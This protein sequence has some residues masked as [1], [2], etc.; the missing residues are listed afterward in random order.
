[1]WHSSSL[2]AD[3]AKATDA[4]HMWISYLMDHGG[5]G[6]GRN[7][8]NWLSGER[9]IPLDCRVHSFLQLFNRVTRLRM[10][11]FLFFF[12]ASTLFGVN[13]TR[14]RVCGS[15]KNTTL[16]SSIAIFVWKCNCKTMHRVYKLN[17]KSLLVFIVRIYSARSLFSIR[18][19]IVLLELIA[20]CDF[21]DG[22]QPIRKHNSIKS[23]ASIRRRLAVQSD[24]PPEEGI[25]LASLA[26]QHRKQIVK[27][28]INIILLFCGVVRFVRDVASP[29]S[30]PSSEKRKKS[31]LFF[32]ISFSP[33]I[34]FSQ[35]FLYRNNFG[36][37][38]AG[39]TL[40]LPS[41]LISASQSAVKIFNWVCLC[42][43]RNSKLSSARMKNKKNKT[44]HEHL[45]AR[46]AYRSRC[47]KMYN[48][49]ACTA[50]EPHPSK[51]HTVAGEYMSSRE[52]KGLT[53]LGVVK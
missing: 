9:F 20:F 19:R 1:M 46:L 24:R 5:E 14:L 37:E 30:T 28:A 11:G 41:Q 51:R 12:F 26:S 38:N 32:L 29:R 45:Y 8:L 47:H 4:M 7:Y 50:R 17:G 13:L 40:I 31:N 22:K 10:N 2:T 23:V 48:A 21:A 34:R 27:S 49:N 52:K 25:T 36:Y 35:Y 33:F 53:L 18:R 39:K 15:I 6:S 43:R 44:D 3:V 42:G 16:I